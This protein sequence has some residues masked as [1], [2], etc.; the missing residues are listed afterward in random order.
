MNFN[1]KNYP[2]VLLSYDEPNYTRNFI[3]LQALYPNALH[4]HGI[5]GSDT[6]HKEVA[7]LVLEEDPTATHVIIVDGDN[8]IRDDFI[9]ASYNFVDD[10]DI[11]NNVV[12]FSAR[13][14]VNGNQYGN[15][16]IKV[17]PIHMLQ[18]MRTHENSDN[19]N[20][21]DFNIA[22]YLE[23]NRVGSD[24]VIN[25]SPLQAWRSG[26]REGY[27]LTLWADY[28]TM[29]WRNYD[30]LWRWMHVGSDVDNGLW[31]IY[32]ARMGCFLALNGYDTSN[33]RDNNHTTEM[34]NGFYDTYKDN[35]EAECNRIG[36]LIRVKTNDQRLINV[37]SNS[38]SQEFRTTIKPILRSP[39]KFIKYKYY[40]PYDVV[41][42]SF[43]EP[44]ADK[45]YNLL[46]EKCPKAKR[47]D[48]VVGIHN[49]HIQ[50]A[51][52]CDT[53]YF[54]V[55]DADSIIMDDFI[56]EYDIDFYS[57]DTVRVWR[58]K[59]PVNGLVYGNGGVKLLPR[60]STLRMLKNKPDMTTSISTHYEPIFKISNITEFNVDS[61]SAWRSA[62]RECVKLSSKIID[63][64][65]DNE[66]QVRLDTWCTLNEDARYGYYCYSGA[67]A[68]KEYGL[69]N[70]GDIEALSKI[71]DYVWLREQYD[72][73]H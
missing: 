23:L 29:N 15:G 8:E 56:F 45:N 11:N 24:T 22:N 58:S 5:F 60:M 52:L 30:R 63:R 38:E 59:N 50:A 4:V 17:W 2:V 44:N 61:F 1:T 53:D 39:E 31:A 18:S 16:G 66:T 37:L 47:I 70:K 26:F 13:N 72:K 71:N 51:K 14:N 35:L 54:W 42:I 49:A 67:L 7:R 6:A 68:G 65:N 73:F 3:K 27:K 10:V 19:P 41:F 55:V 57:I 28:S 34:F 21:I 9:N 33:L 40:P 43:N 62:F 12:S 36:N 20:S 25:D 64:Q 46:K 48:G 69:K 32:G